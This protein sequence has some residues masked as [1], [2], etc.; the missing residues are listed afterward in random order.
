MP[1]PTPSPQTLDAAALARV[2]DRIAAQLVPGWT[3]Q[4]VPVTREQIDQLIPGALAVCRPDQD[5]TPTRELATVY[6]VTPWPGHESLDETLWHE[7]THA[8]MSDLVQLIPDRDTAAGVLVEEKIVER[9]GKILARVPMAA[10]RA[11]RRS[12]EG[13][14]LPAPV[15]A[16]LSAAAEPTSRATARASA[17]G[18][19]MDPE[20]V[21]ML[22]EAIKG[23]DGPKALELL[24]GFLVQMAAAGVEA[25]EPP[26]RP[27]AAMMGTYG[28]DAAPPPADGA[29]A[30]T[31]PPPP[32]HARAEMEARASARKETPVT[33]KDTLRARKEAQDAAEELKL[34][35]ADQ[36]GAAKETLILGLRARLGAK[37]TP[38]AE[39][40]IMSAPTYQ[41]AKDLAAFAEELGGVGQRARA[42]GPDGQPLQIEANPGDTPGVLRAEELIKEGLPQM[43]ARDIAER[44]KTDP[45]LAAHELKAARGRL[46]TGQNPW[47]PPAN[48]AV[49]VS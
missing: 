5:A 19:Q 46:S 35:A 15:R 14:T 21:K 31:D 22:I 27:G 23:G 32:P 18:G 16:R 49:K 47:L 11:I 20:M 39:K 10:R 37:L 1:T 44:S 9:L 3:I 48:G 2:G 45:K 33:D 7:L 12:I 36:R 13:L 6:V 17:R 24:E 34:I 40:R 4:W 25:T 26:S 42:A 38:A 29:P 41:Q 30:K 8:L 28:K 43:L